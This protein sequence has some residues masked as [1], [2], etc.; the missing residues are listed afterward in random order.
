MVD[1]LISRPPRSPRVPKFPGPTSS[2]FNLNIARTSLQTMGIAGS[3]EEPE[4]PVMTK[5]AS[6]GSPRL[7]SV[8]RAPDGMVRDPI[9]ALNREEALRLCDVFDDEFSLMHPILDVDSVKRHASNLFKFLDA[10]KR[11]QMLRM[12]TRRGPDAMSDEETDV[13][14]LI[15]ACALAAENGGAT[16]MSTSLFDYV[17][18][19]NESALRDEVDLK[20]VRLL[21]LVAMYHFHVG[22]ESLAWRVIGLAA[23]GCLELGLHRADTYKIMFPTDGPRDMAMLMF[24]SIFVMDRRMSLA[25]GMSSALQDSDIDPLLPPPN[26]PYLH[27]LVAYS[28]ISSKVWKS[29][30]A[31]D[32]LSGNFNKEEIDSLDYQITQWFNTIPEPLRYYHPRSSEYLQFAEQQ[33]KHPHGIN[34]AGG[35]AQHRL[36]AMLYLKANIMRIVLFRPALQSASH[37]LSNNSREHAYKAVAIAKDTIFVLTHINETSDIYRTQQTS[38]NAFLLSAVAVL[39]LAVSHAPAQFSSQ[40]RDEFYQALDLVR[41]LSSQSHVSKRLWRTIRSLKAI[42][43]KLGLYA[44]PQDEQSSPLAGASRDQ[45]QQEQQDASSAA[46]AMAGLAGH[47][48]DEAAFFAAHP[49]PSAPPLLP[50]SGNLTSPDSMA[51]DLTRLFEAAGGFGQPMQAGPMAP[52]APNAFGEEGIEGMSWGNEDELNRVM[53]DMF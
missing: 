45:S 40:C 34:C 49:G 21:A 31:A 6:S 44:R 50:G 13:L 30:A 36:R 17:S 43:P 18:A 53:R 5:D 16:D 32:A 11:D 33:P 48:V 10:I 4:E 35:R 25:T 39:F 7:A 41:G 28:K 19:S 52:A 24:W 38:F 42:G 1:P 15:M 46:M 29:V 14:K 27:A 20:T 22:D 12:G 8:R 2:A 3:E 37:M 23:R 26:S 9:W 47:R 51:N